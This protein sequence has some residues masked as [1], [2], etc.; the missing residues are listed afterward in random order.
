MS[1]IWE[2]TRK[3]REFYSIPHLEQLTTCIQCRGV[4][5][6]SSSGRLESEPLGTSF[7]CPLIMMVKLIFSFRV[8]VFMSHRQPQQCTYPA[9]GRAANSCFL[10]SSASVAH[11]EGYSRSLRKK[12]ERSSHPRLQYPLAVMCHYQCPTWSQQ[13]AWR[14][15]GREVPLKWKSVGCTRPDPVNV[16]V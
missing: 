11:R 16:H 7:V 12:V 8:P 1:T 10:R 2:S 5:E 15:L 3:I 6:T 13:A 9:W 14:S 4:G